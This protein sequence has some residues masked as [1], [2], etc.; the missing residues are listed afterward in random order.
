MELLRE[1]KRL[2]WGGPPHSP[3]TLG[4]KHYIGTQSV[5]SLAER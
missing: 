5:V 4:G 1:K 3:G 2:N